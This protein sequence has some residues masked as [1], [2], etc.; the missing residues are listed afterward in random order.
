MFALPSTVGGLIPGQQ[1]SDAMMRDAALGHPVPASV[2][3]W[4]R[5]R[6]VDGGV[7]G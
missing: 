6:S 2:E 7:V 4:K 3:A 1:P 5:G